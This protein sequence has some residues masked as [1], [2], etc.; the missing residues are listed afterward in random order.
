MR[1]VTEYRQC[2][3]ILA[4]DLY[5]NELSVWSI[6]EDGTYLRCEFMESLPTRPSSAAMRHCEIVE[7]LVSGREIEEIQE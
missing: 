1:V 4:S 5:Y 3:A 6:K 2:S 7:R